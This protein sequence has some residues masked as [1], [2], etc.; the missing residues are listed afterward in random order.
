MFVFIA[1][2]VGMLVYSN[3]CMGHWKHLEEGNFVTDFATQTTSITK[4]NI[5][6]AHM[7]SC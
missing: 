5:I 7:R 6:K 2:G 1:I 4:W 3:V